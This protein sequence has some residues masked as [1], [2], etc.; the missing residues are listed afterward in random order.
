M[1]R[2]GHSQRLPRERRR[3]T[4][5]EETMK[6]VATIVIAIIGVVSNIVNTTRALLRL[7]EIWKIMAFVGSGLVIFG[8]G[9][10]LFS[11]IPG[12]PHDVWEPAQFWG[13]VLPIAIG[14][15]FLLMAGALYVGINRGPLPGT[16]GFI[17]NAGLEGMAERPPLGW[18]IVWAICAVI[19]AALARASMKHLFTPSIALIMKSAWEGSWG[20]ALWQLPLLV[21]GFIGLAYSAD[22]LVR[23]FFILVE[24]F[25]SD[26]DEVVATEKEVAA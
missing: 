14:P 10:K 3:V 24:M 8:S 23:P 19:G 1:P 2:N 18:A 13:D 17:E 7:K 25:Y 11:F 26:E 21:A 15:A 16:L 20:V 4:R 9:L 5:K 22:L 12:L 6:K